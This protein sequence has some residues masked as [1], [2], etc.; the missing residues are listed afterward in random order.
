[1]RFLEELIGLEYKGACSRDAGSIAGCE[2]DEAAFGKAKIRIVRNLATFGVGLGHGLLYD[3][4]ERLPGRRCC[5][6]ESKLYGT[7]S[8]CTLDD[9]FFCWT[10]FY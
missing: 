5:F 8:S 3:P 2:V 9:F 1:L 6:N 7:A 4:A 10:V